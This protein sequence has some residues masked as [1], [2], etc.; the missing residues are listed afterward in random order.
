MGE[1]MK[2]LRNALG[3]LLITF[4]LAANAYATSISQIVVL[5]D[6]LSDNGNVYNAIGYPPFPYW[7]GRFSNGPV[8]VEYLAQS[9]GV[10]LRDFAWGGATTGVGNYLDNGT[11]N[12]FGTF[13]LPGMTTVFQGALSAAQFPIDPNALYIVWGGPNDFWNVATPADASLAIGK[14]VTDLVTIVGTLQSL[15][16]GQILV[17]GMPDMGNTPAL[18]ALGP[19]YSGFFTQISLGFNQ[20][21][22]A[23]L[24]PGVQYFDTFSVLSNLLSNPGLYGLENV[25]EPCFTGSSLC[26]NPDKYLF[27]DGVHPTTV[28]HELLGNLLY[29]RVVPEP[30]SFTL[31]SLGIIGLIGYGWRHRIR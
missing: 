24:P 30:S 10:P 11:V 4:A 8:A 23:N 21:L 9:L 2:T 18:L 16:A 22:Q 28:G 14:A 5:G 13:G 20:A 19:L 15:G 7:Q 6:S 26:T 31:L 29:Q 17:P 27:F 1:Y 3:A 12:Q 25:T